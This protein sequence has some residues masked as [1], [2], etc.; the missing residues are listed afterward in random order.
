MASNNQT[1]DVQDPLQRFIETRWTQLADA[2]EK[3]IEDT[4]KYLLL[5]NSGAAVAVLTFIGTDERIR[6]M[7][8]PTWMLFSFTLGVIFCGLALIFRVN[9]LNKLFSAWRADVADHSAG[10]LDWENLINRDAGRADAKN[11]TSLFRNLAFFCFVA[12][13]I[14]GGFNFNSTAKGEEVGRQKQNTTEAPAA[15]KASAPGAD[16]Q[17]NKQAK[18]GPTPVNPTASP[19]NQKEI[20]QDS[21][22]GTKP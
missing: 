12:G 9:R 22:K 18:P 5:V 6:E 16:G 2:F 8:W 4:S 11:L 1:S 10:K 7:T 3:S 14:I 21:D 19:A 20:K 15:T 17:N 13:V